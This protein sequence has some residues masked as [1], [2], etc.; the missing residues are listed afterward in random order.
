VS[1]SIPTLRGG[2][3]GEASSPVVVAADEPTSLVPDTFA[4]RLYTML[5]PLAKDD[6]ENGWALLIYCNAVGMMFQLI[7][8]LVRD[9]PDGPGW[10]SLMDLDRCP[11]AA[12]PWLGQFVG[13]RIPPGFT[14]EQ[15]RARIASTDGFKRG[16]LAAMRGA[17]EGLLTGNQSVL[18]TERSGDPAIKPD[19]AYYL[20]VHT[21]TDETPWPIIGTTPL[22]LTV[23]GNEI[24]D[25]TR[26]ANND[27]DGRTA[28]DSSFG[29]WEATTN[30]VAQGSFESNITGWVGNL[31]TLSQD[32]T[33]FKFGSK[34]MK[35]QT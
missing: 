27:G 2:A 24:T 6:N 5:A 3:F 10:S 35:V 16:T 7:E 23:S 22:A 14:P 12:L 33:W 15:A 21:Y 26:T 29:I 11:D 20:T 9:T 34:S 1:S 30:L 17:V 31:A 4:A 25:V 32:A 19:Y 8:D 13:V 28:P 18:F